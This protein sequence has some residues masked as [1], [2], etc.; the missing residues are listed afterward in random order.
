MV[1]LPWIMRD[2]SRKRSKYPFAKGDWRLI[3]R[4]VRKAPRPCSSNDLSPLLSTNS[5]LKRKLNITVVWCSGCLKK[6]PRSE[7]VA[8]FHKQQQRYISMV[9]S[10]LASHRLSCKLCLQTR[11]HSGVLAGIAEND[12]DSPSWCCLLWTHCQRWQTCW[13]AL[14]LE[15][16]CEQEWV[17]ST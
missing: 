9:V 5:L 4:Y 17:G 16:L 7:Y 11:I 14:R 12:L 8:H 13:L 6:H 2:F 10:F 3:G 15:A 1:S